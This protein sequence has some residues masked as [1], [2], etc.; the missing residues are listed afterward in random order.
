M[1]LFQSFL[2]AYVQE[3]VFLTFTVRIPGFQ[4][5]AVFSTG[6]VSLSKS[7]C[8]FTGA[9]HIFY[10]REVSWMGR[11]HEEVTGTRSR[12]CVALCSLSLGGDSQT[13]RGGL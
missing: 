8:C 10:L 13:L 9:V 4:S 11:C 2:V 1:C 12:G 5:F 6:F 3:V 7:F